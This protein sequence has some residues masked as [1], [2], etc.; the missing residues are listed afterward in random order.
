MGASHLCEF[1]D[2]SQCLAYAWWRRHHLALASC[3]GY[4]EHGR[5]PFAG[6]TYVYDMQ[7]R[8]SLAGAQAL[9]SRS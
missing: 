6:Y 7:V 8:P 5:R 2:F 3:R 9:F 4:L 1:Q